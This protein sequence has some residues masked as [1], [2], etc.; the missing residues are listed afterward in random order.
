M[1]KPNNSDSYEIME[2]IQE[3]DPLVAE[4]LRDCYETIS[5]REQDGNL[6]IFENGLK[7]VIEL[8]TI[9]K[10]QVAERQ[11]KG[12]FNAF[13]RLLNKKNENSLVQSEQEIFD[14]I[15]GLFYIKIFSEEG[16][17]SK[18]IGDFAESI[19]RLDYSQK[20]PDLSVEGV[21]KNLF[22]YFGFALE[23]I[24]ESMSST[25]F[26]KKS[27]NAYFD[28]EPDVLMLVTDR[29]Y[30]I[31][32]IN[33]FGEFLFQTEHFE[34]EGNSLGTLIPELGSEKI[35]ALGSKNRIK[36]PLV[37]DTEKYGIRKVELSYLIC[38]NED[39]VSE[40]VFILNFKDSKFEALSKLRE[41][42]SVV[43]K[44]IDGIN[45][46]RQ[47]SLDQKGIEN[48]SEI[49]QNLHK[50]KDNLGAE[51]PSDNQ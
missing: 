30:N 24:A 16:D 33:K 48:T 34:I 19:M 49:L 50:L 12:I 13:N 35:S 21:S 7:G 38:D 11:S 18:R 39:E 23:S 44:V 22:N 31:R 1:K 4:I 25:T 15:Q 2:N 9:D 3:G 32:S 45:N 26:S 20:L 36:E 43:N 40:F 8:A 51:L 17:I 41:N 10:K 37:L 29:N 47:T 14:K 5:S 27:I 46:L 28:T 6:T 42:Y